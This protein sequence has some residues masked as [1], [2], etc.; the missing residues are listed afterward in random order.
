MATAD[1]DKSGLISR[2]QRVYRGPTLGW[3]EAYTQPQTVVAITPYTLTVGD[4]V[5]LLNLAGVQTINLP[6]C[7]VWV[8]EF[9]NVYDNP[10][11]LAIWIKD[12]G[13]NAASFNKTI[14]PFSGDTIDGLAA[15]DFTIVQNRA[16]LRLYP[17]NDL[18]G[19]FSG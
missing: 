11:E 5:I 3:A 16:L 7:S 8:N 6:K 19:W 1:L 17:L 15:T 10:S 18:T 13:G 12:F 2:R 9:L 14:H 4:G